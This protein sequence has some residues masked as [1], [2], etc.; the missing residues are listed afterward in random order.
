M[1]KVIAIIA[2]GIL[3]LE[4]YSQ[5]TNVYVYDMGKYVPVKRSKAE[6]ERINAKAAEENKKRIAKYADER[7]L[8]DLIWDLTGQVSTAEAIYTYVLSE[9]STQEK[10]LEAKKELDSI[11]A[12]RQLYLDEWN[13]KGY[14]VSGRKRIK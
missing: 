8:D 4:S 12:K 7:E 3:S 1:K 10:I 2:M 14:N 11:L 13:R 9:N 5:N 6:I